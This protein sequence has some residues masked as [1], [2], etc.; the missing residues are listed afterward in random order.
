MATYTRRY[1][2]QE[3]ATRPP[4]SAPDMSSHGSANASASSSS[5]TA[6]AAATTTRRAAKRPPVSRT[7][8]HWPGVLGLVLTSCLVAGAPRVRVVRPPRLL[9]SGNYWERL[10]LGMGHVPPAPSTS[11]CVSGLLDDRP[12]WWDG[13]TVLAPYPARDPFW[14]AHLRLQ[15]AYPRD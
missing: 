15:T 11:G 4:T 9:C 14:L 7:L 1:R 3:A 12:A 10:L 2:E 6:A 8:G 5:V 13:E